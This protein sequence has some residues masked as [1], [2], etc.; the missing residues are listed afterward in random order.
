MNS[1]EAMTGKRRLAKSEG[2]VIRV[3]PFKR[4][5]KIAT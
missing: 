1:G 4:S 3:I 5:V 2:S